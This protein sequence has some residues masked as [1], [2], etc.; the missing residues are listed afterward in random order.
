MQQ[1][2]SIDFW[3]SRSV[4]QSSTPV[5]GGAERHHNAWA[6]AL[7]SALQASLLRTIRRIVG[8]ACIWP[9]LGRDCSVHHPA[10]SVT[11]CDVCSALW[12]ALRGLSHGI[13]KCGCPLQA[14]VAS[15]CC[16]G[17]ACCLRRA[18]QCIDAQYDTDV[19][20]W[21]PQGRIHQIEYAM[22]AVKQGSAAV[23][24]KVNPEITVLLRA[25]HRAM[26]FVHPT[27][28]LRT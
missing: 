20:T 11:R 9:A 13:G 19:V 23:G 21:S 6:C 3:L 16:C 18:D 2:H 25:R 10:C 24:L 12:T 5:R 8:I 1:E 28:R 22:E 27:V 26:L 7:L 4:W 15:S 14:L 17:S